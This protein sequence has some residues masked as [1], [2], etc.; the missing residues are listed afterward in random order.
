MI[1]G[2]LEYIMSSLPDLYF[3]NTEEERLKVLGL[4][5]KYADPSNEPEDAVGILNAE[6]RKFMGQ[7]DYSLFEQIDLLK[8]HKDI[9][10]SNRDPV[11]S[12]FAE[13]MAQLKEELRQLRLSRNEDDDTGT[14]KKSTFP[15]IPGDPLEEEIQ[16]LKWQWDKLE[17]LSMGEYA[18]FS[19][20]AAYKLKLQLLVRWWNFDE[21]RGFDHFANLIEP[22]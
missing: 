21:E 7:S 3:Q 20:L 5:K 12:G 17:A 10:R 16:L 13:Y 2:D 18:N 11:V 1:T 19:A 22:N 8:I 6:A 9:F 14:V 4:L 15:L